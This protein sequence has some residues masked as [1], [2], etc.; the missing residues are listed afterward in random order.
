MAKYGRIFVSMETCYAMIVEAYLVDDEKRTT[1]VR[2]GVIERELTT[3]PLGLSL[4]EGK[5]L[6]ASAQEI[7]CSWAVPVHRCCTRPLRK[8]RCALEQQGHARAADSN[9]VRAGNRP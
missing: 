3:D 7:S 9:R 4:A 6:L 1:S 8:V 5:A 2:L